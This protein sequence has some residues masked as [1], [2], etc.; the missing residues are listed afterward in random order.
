VLF[1]TE[2][3]MDQSNI[4]R[5]YEE[6]AGWLSIELWGMLSIIFSNSIY[7]FLR[8]FF[9]QRTYLNVAEMQK[10]E[11]TDFLESQQVL[12]AIFN[13][14]IA[15]IFINLSIR[16]TFPDSFVGYWI[17]NFQ[18]P[19]TVFQSVTTVYIIF[20]SFY[21][22]WDCIQGLWLTIG[23]CIHALFVLLD[24]V[25]IP[26]TIIVQIFLTEAEVNESL[27]SAGL[28][29]YPLI[30][31][32]IFVQGILQVGPIFLGAIGLTR[33]LKRQQPM[34]KG[35]KTAEEWDNIIDEM[36]LDDNYQGSILT[37]A[38]REELRAA[39]FP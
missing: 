10:T 34:R 32:G 21:K 31:F 33:R 37:G 12:A 5:S 1:E 4:T 23:P 16:K 19:F 13:S 26:I 2:K 9:A 39:L 3:S 36:E 18:L 24:F 17:L 27:F 11:K 6:W 20:V 25:V 29:L 22:G 8:S 38:E 7:L 14:L 28:I 35:A 15:P 30:S